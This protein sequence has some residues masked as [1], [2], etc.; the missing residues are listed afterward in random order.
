LSTIGT[1]I[2]L[3]PQ[4]YPRANSFDLGLLRSQQQQQFFPGLSVA[5]TMPSIPEAKLSTPQFDM[6]PPQSAGLAAPI[7]LNPSIGCAASTSSC[8]SGGIT[9]EQLSALL[10]LFY[11]QPAVSTAA[12]LVPQMIQPV[13]QP[14]PTLQELLLLAS[15]QQSLQQ[16]SQQL[17]PPPEDKNNHCNSAFIDVC[18]V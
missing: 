18:S 13:M 1:E 6:T 11:Q 12:S 17:S 3:S 9:T 8:G 15:L 2:S 14:Q 4:Q 16:Q 5:Q 7:P 10:Q